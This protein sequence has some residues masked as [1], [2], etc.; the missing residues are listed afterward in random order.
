MSI[1]CF[2]IVLLLVAAAS[3]PASAQDQDADPTSAASRAALLAAEREKKATETSLPQRSKVERAL[4]WYDD[5]WYGIP[6]VFQSW[7]GL[8]LA[9]SR[10]P[11]GAGVKVAVGFTHDL[12]R[13][14]PAADPDR[15]NRVEI[16]ALGAYSTRDYSRGEVDINIYHLGG[17]PLSVRVGAQHYEFPQQDFFGFGQQSVEDN[18]T[19]YLL[20]S[21]EAGAAVQRN[22]L[23]VIEITG[24]VSYLNP[25]IAP[26]TD[27]CFPS[28]EQLFDPA[29]IPGYEQQPDFLRS[30][31]SFASHSTG[32]TIRCTR[33]RGD[34][35]VCGSPTTAIR[36]STRST[37][38]GSR[39]TFNITYPFQTVTGR[40]RFTPRRSLPMRTRGRRYRSISSPR[41]AVRRRREGFIPC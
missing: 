16:D 5:N 17:A 27:N 34:A 28:T 19:N 33:T 40:L 21:T 31:A 3:A 18:R 4:L 41:W 39:S 22:A 12:G 38:A 8:H 1:L 23:S 15:P 26:G 9:D 29:T 25:T 37:S 13:I 14:R 10:F 2:W 35:T 6:F 11:A 30:D 24:G 20:R 36:I 32:A 7:H